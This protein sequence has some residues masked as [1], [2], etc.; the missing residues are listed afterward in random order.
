[1]THTAG[2]PDYFDES[3]TDDFEAIWADNPVYKL[4]APKHF[5]PLFQAMKMNFE[6][7]ERFA[8]SNSGYILLGLVVET[9]SGQSYQEFVT[10]HV[11]K[12][13]QMKNTGFFRMDMLPENTA[14]GHIYDE[15]LKGW[16]T[17]IFS[18][19][20]IGGPDGGLFTTAADMNAF[21]EHL[22]G[23]KLLSEAMTEAMLAPRATLNADVGIYY[24][25]G[26]YMAKVNEETTR[27][28]VLGADPGV[29][30]FSVYYPLKKVTA[31]ALANTESNIFSLLK[32]LNEIW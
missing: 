16:R 14:R 4:T 24:G 31:T 21:W 3:V 20:V 30:F 11:L 27:Y 9:I 17:N 12:P 28:Y 7:G 2:V 22:I 6:P 8:Y 23:S 18:V 26:V 1:M 29:Q 32:E 13:C 15:D 25:L 10:E 19:P 5:L